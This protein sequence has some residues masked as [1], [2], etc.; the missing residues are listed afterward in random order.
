MVNLQE[1]FPGTISALFRISDKL[2][3]NDHAQDESADGSQGN[4]ILCCA[5]METATE[6]S[7]YQARLVSEAISR[8][9]TAAGDELKIDQLTLNVSE[10][11]GSSGCG[12]STSGC[13]RSQ[14]DVP[15]F[16]DW[17]DALCYGCRVTVED[18]NDLSAMPSVLQE[19]IRQRSRR[20][21]MRASVEQFL[22]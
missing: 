13:C 10:C 16:K 5:R 1:G 6:C 20:R 2:K 11:D 9:S 17:K 19:E 8:S 22:L 3:S 4:C 21:N 7:A 14:H 12:S 15:P 18:V